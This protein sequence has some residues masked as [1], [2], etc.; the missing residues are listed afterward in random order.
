MWSTQGNFVSEIFDKLCANLGITHKKTTPFHPQSNGCIERIH[1]Q[2]KSALRALDNPRS[3]STHL[4]LIMLAMNNLV[5]DRNSFSPF[6]MTLGQAALI[7]G[8][9]RHSSINT[10]YQNDATSVLAFIE[11][12]AHHKK[13]ARPLPDNKPFVDPNLWTCENVWVRNNT[14]SGAL[15]PLYK[16]PY[17]VLMRKD[18]FFTVLSETR[19]PTKVSIDNLKAALTTLKNSTEHSANNTRFYSDSNCDLACRTDVNGT[20]TTSDNNSSSSSA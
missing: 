4:P 11:N 10:N 3:W 16:G 6:Q 18:K 14:P 1:R 12:M 20:S 8:N 17:K 7:N 15:A 9:C 19:G 5:A 13:K 2:L